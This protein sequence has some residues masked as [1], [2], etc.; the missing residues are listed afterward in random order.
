[1]LVRI[2]PVGRE[3][4][5]PVERRIVLRSECFSGCGAACVTLKSMTFKY[6]TVMMMKY[7][8]EVKRR[9]GI[10]HESKGS[11]DN[12]ERSTRAKRSSCLAMFSAEA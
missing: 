7:P 2:E 1:M 10:E 6:I 5:F 4:Q 8:Y 3:R 9:R 11:R 12:R